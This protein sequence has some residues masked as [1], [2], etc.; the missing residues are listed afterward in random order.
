[1]KI[2]SAVTVLSLLLSSPLW[3]AQKAEDFD[4]DVVLTNPF[5]KDLVNQPVFLQV[6]RVFGRGVDYARFHRDGFHVYDEKGAEL[7]LGYRSLPPAF[8]MADDELVLMLP[9]LAPGARVTVRFTNTAARNPKLKR[10]EAGGLIEH[11]G[12]LIPN[13][14]F[15]KGQEGWAGGAVVAE[16]V[17]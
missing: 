12:N 7:D 3:A 10:L 6:F 9:S 2:L 4:V 17:H 11:P 13:G 8:S 14:G 15:E 16:G 5:A 1:M